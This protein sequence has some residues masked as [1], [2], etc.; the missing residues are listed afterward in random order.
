MEVS[1]KKP[2]AEESEKTR[3]TREKLGKKL[4][5]IQSQVTEA[6]IKRKAHE[7]QRWIARHAS[8]R[9][10]LKKKSI[11]LFDNNQN[12]AEFSKRIAVIA[13]QLRHT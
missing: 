9:I 8:N 11:T 10:S 3:K 13:Q 7:I 2:L 5:K 12:S 1:M 6:A 4:N